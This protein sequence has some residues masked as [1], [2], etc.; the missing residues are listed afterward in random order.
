MVWA[1]YSVVQQTEQICFYQYIFLQNIR[2][3]R[4]VFP[5][6]D[7]N[8]VALDQVLNQNAK[9][10]SVWE[11]AYLR[12]Y[13]CNILTL[14]QVVTRTEIGQNFHFLLRSGTDQKKLIQAAIH[15]FPKETQHF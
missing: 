14:G 6:K 5:G 9:E 8:V 7:V 13:K 4:I 3:C 10:M 1:V 12:L 11:I 2:K 15:S